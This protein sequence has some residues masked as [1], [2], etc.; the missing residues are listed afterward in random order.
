M[1]TFHGHVVLVIKSY[2]ETTI[3]LNKKSDGIKVN[4]D[5]TILIAIIKFRLLGLIEG[6]LFAIMYAFTINFYVHVQE[7][8]Y[9][10]IMLSKTIHLRSYYAHM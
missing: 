2:S 9:L 4:I 3:I 7:F 6:M 1:Y 5:M 10:Q 8:R